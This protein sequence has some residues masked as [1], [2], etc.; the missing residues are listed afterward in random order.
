[1]SRLNSGG[2]SASGASQTTAIATAARRPGRSRH[3]ASQ[4]TDIAAIPTQTRCTPA[5]RLPG[6]AG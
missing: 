4:A 3:S 5:I 1:M 2:A 6:N